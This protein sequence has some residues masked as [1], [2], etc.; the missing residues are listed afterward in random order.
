MMAFFL[1]MWLLNATT[2]V[3]RKGLSDYFNPTIPVSRISSGGAGMLDGSTRF[4]PDSM[5]GSSSEGTPPKPTHRD[6]G[7]TVADDRASPPDAIPGENP[8]HGGAG[9]AQLTDDQQDT[10]A[11]VPRATVGPGANQQAAAERRERE[12]LEQI[13]RKIAEAMQHTEDGSLARH[14]VFHIT[15]EGLVIEIID[16]DDRPLFGS[17]SAQPTPV[18]NVL[19]QILVP[20]LDETVNDIAVVG[21]TDAVPFG[22]IGYTNWELSADRANTARHL[23][24]ANGLPEAR[25]SRV[26]GKAAME[27]LVADPNAPQNRRIALI[28]LREPAR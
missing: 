13:Q 26:S 1:L 5:A 7:K 27:P 19:T 6:P 9:A 16:V 21:H 11:E 2:E 17:A 8:A 14:F 15:P 3:Q 10:G 4:N 28:L 20:V 22:S 18:L 23:L 25:I 24:T 12:R